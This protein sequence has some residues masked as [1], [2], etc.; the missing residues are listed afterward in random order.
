MPVYLDHAATT[1]VDARVLAAMQP[2]WSEKFYNPSSLYRAGRQARQALEKA[3]AEV[4][5]ILGAKGA[6]IIFSAGATESINLIMFG[7]AKQFAQTNVVI[8]QIEHETVIKSA[9]AAFGSAR[10]RLCPVKPNG[11]IDPA[12]LAEF[13]SD[14]TV[15]IGVMYANNE[16]GTI[17]P[18]AKIA[19][20]IDGIRKDRAKRAV[21]RPLYLHSD[22]SQA[23]DYLDLHVNRLGVDLLT[24]NGSK[25]YGPKQTGATYIKT[26]VALAPWL[27]G[28]GQE[29][30]LRSGTENVAGSVGF[31]QALGL[32]VALRRQESQRLS[33]VR[34]YALKKLSEII[35]DVTFNGDL[36][37]RLP[38]NINLSVP[39]VEGQMLVHALDTRGVLVATGSACIADV[40]KPSHVLAAL[41]LPTDIGNSALRVTMGRST[42]KLEIDYFVE[43]LK[44]AIERLKQ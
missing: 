11:I 23:A 19:R 7:F 3:R 14:K 28:G 20:L 15:L 36:T 8:S 29:R 39:G 21:E 42:G 26:G 33:V 4:A 22:A 9:T 1:P 12:K 38:N 25:I 32:A 44:T 6:E 2:F 41:G 34:D 18:I 40:D 5:H 17:Q 43:Q 30:G 10:V 35:K 31:A 16:I 27:H 13:I 24:L 37:R